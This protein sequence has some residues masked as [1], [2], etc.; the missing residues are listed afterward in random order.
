MLKVTKYLL[1]LLLFTSSTVILAQPYGNEWINYNQK[2]F[3]VKVASDGVYRINAATFASACAAAG[4]PVGS[5]NPQNLQVFNKGVEQFIYVEGEANGS[6]D[7]GDYIE[8]YAQHNDA[9]FDSSL[10]FGISYLPNPYYS[11]FNDTAAYFLT[12]NNSTANKRFVSETDTTFSAYTPADY[13]INDVAVVPLGNYYDGET[14]QSGLGITDPQYTKAEGYFS[15]FGINKSSN[16]PGVLTVPVPTKNVYLAGPSAQSR[17]VL[18]GESQDGS[19]GNDHHLTIE[20]VGSGSLTLL[21]DQKFYGYKSFPFNYT[22]TPAQLGSSTTNFVLSTLTDV[23]AQS[24][25]TIALSYIKLSY[26]HTYD[27]EGAANFTMYVPDHTVLSK[28]FLNISNF[29]TAGANDT[30]RLFDLTN[31]RRIKVVKNGSVANAFKALVPNGGQKKCFITSDAQVKT[32]A[33]LN[34][35]N[36]SG[37][38]TN[39]KAQA[40]DS[41]YLIVTHRSL[42]TEVSNYKNYRS[43]IAGGSHNVIVTDI[44][45]LYDQFAY[46]INKHPLAV[47]GFA[48]YTLDSFPTKPQFL[49]L[50]GKSINA[51][52]CR[53]GGTNYSACLVPT[54]GNPSVDIMFTS[55]LNGTYLEP[56]IATGRL[57]ARTPADVKIYLD[58][59]RDYES[60]APADWMKEVLHFAGGDDVYQNQTF[61]YFLDS[62]KKIIEDT[63][64]GG[65]VKTYSK[66]SSD[67]IS[68]N[69]SAELKDRINKG[70]SLMTFFGHSSGQSWDIGI[71]KPS[72]YD[73]KPRYPFLLSNGCYAGDIHKDYATLENST[74]SEQFILTQDKGAIGFL[75]AGSLGLSNV[76]QEYSTA[77]NKK[78]GMDEYGSPIGKCIKAAIKSIEGGAVSDITRKAGYL[79]MTLHGDPA[80]IINSPRLPDYNIT[81]S[82]VSFNTTYKTDTF[83]V[84]VAHSNLGRAINRNY[85]IEIVRTF[86]NGKMQTYLIDTLAPKFRDTLSIKMPVDFVNGVGL[87]KFKVTLDFMGSITEMSELNNVTLPDAELLIRGNVIIPVYPY[88]YAIIPNNTVRL[89]ASTANVFAGAIS[90]KFQIDT[91]DAFNSPVM[92]TS[93]ITSA[94]GVV[95]WTPPVTLTDSTVYYWRVSADSTSPLNPFNWRESSFQYI[96]GKRGWGQAHFFQFKN[97]GYQYVQYNKPQRRFD[98]VNDIKSIHVQTMNYWNYSQTDRSSYDYPQ[99]WINTDVLMKAGCG[100]SNYSFAR[101]SPVTGI[102]EQ[103]QYDAAKTLTDG[104]GENLGQYYNYHCLMPTTRPMNVFVYHNYDATWLQRIKNFVDSVPTGHYVM[105]YTQDARLFKSGRDSALYTTFEKIGSSKIRTIN[106]SMPYIIFGVKGGAIGTAKESI[107]TYFKQQVQ[108]DTSFTTN[109][110][111]GYVASEII[112]PALS[113]DSLF[114]RQQKLETSASADSIRLR[115]IGIK[116]DGTET[117]IVNGFVTDSAEVNLKPYLNASTYPYIKLVAYMKDDSLHDP[118]QLVR[119][120]VIY[121][122]VPEAAINPLAAGGLTFYNDTVQEGDNVKLTYPVQNISEYDFVDSILI[123]SWVEDNKGVMHTNPDRMKKKPFVAGEIMYDTITVNTE[124]FAGYNNLW[125]EVNPVGKPKS[126]LEQY[127]FNNIM[128]LGFTVSSD[129][130]NPLLD[131][132]FDGIHILDRDIVSAK[133]SILVKLKDENKFL[134]LNSPDD[135]AVFIK[136]PSSSA[137]EPVAF[138][139]QLTFT[140]AVLPNN[141]CKINYTP[142]FAEDGIYELTVQAKDRS[143]NLSGSLD[144]KTRFEVI[145]KSTITELMNYPNPFSTATRFV[146]TLTGTEIPD[147]LKVQ[148]MTV[149]G[150]VVREITRDQLG[151]I[152][153]GRNITEYA[154]DGKDEFGDQLGNGIYLYHVQ[155]RLNGASIE[156]RAS[157]ADAFFTRGFGKMY[158]MR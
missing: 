148:I 135:F 93:T 27:L 154:W 67:P 58:K 51:K 86:P 130:I 139:S 113:W 2:Y 75:A 16:T 103:S 91:T 45:E 88:N 56:A 77:I 119:W 115:V 92:S 73:N 39:Y 150:K 79:E 36:V 145:T 42:M 109:W 108:L 136:K 106:D 65:H 48:D 26:P 131:V 25:G 122:P 57:A 50:I 41:A 32:V 141:S 33:S 111:E 31:G 35:V 99:F 15:G 74:N 96:N 23:S 30:V 104:N 140:P 52:D 40:A 80:V 6:F 83:I 82:D 129:H 18:S 158:L 151:P 5:V 13:F 155:T 153:I 117:V 59:V 70:V 8:F 110:D 127:H 61:R 89:K 133:P 54:F 24:P 71:D 81:T 84:S 142:S 107:G 11:L 7:S 85:V 14:A 87:N 114:W 102:P 138:G 38:F 12:W 20:Y 95:E 4:V 66:V 78:I 143:G 1:F 55:G 34:P 46:G 105:C 47:R 19:M 43:S 62:Y 49:F 147:N 10:Y 128:S 63:L 94:G 97:D 118:P 68:I 101:I 3:K 112:G 64:F 125:V 22:F 9:K 17:L 126:Q 90:Y 149:T 60:N 29:T 116:S 28:S 146:F 152:H 21:T 134:A 156:K 98:F 132:T 121:T 53:K 120:Q 44:D 72:S 124:G 76:L 137:T 100:G 144:Y 69:T 157:G 37:T 123:T